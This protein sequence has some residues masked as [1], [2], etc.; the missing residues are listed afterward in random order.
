[1]GHSYRSA[2]EGW[3]KMNMNTMKFFVL[4]GVVSSLPLWAQPTP[5]PTTGDAPC[6]A[7]PSGAAASDTVVSAADDSGFYSMFDGASF[8]GWWQSCQTGHSNG[9]TQ[10]AIFRIDAAQKAIYST[11][12]NG[13]I[14]GILMSAKKYTNYEIVFDLWPDYGN[15]GGLFNRTPPNGNCFQTVLDYIDGAAMGATWGEGGFTARD[16]RPFAFHGAE[17]L[18]TIPGNGAGDPSNWTV[19]TSRLNPT[20]FGCPA[21]GCTQTEWQALWDMDGWNQIRIKFYG[22][23][24]AGTGNIHMKAYFR[25]VGAANWVPLSQDTTLSQIVPPNHI[26][27]QVHGGGRFGGQ[28]GTWYRNIK[29]RTLNDKG[30]PPP[31]TSTFA[32]KKSNSHFDITAS[33]SAL[34]GNLGADHEI[35]VKDMNGRTL[36]T[37]SGHAGKF[38]YSFKSNVHGRLSL[39]VKTAAGVESMSVLRAQ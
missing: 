23:S 25:K 39:Q 17:N 13:N 36:E 26:G 14:G 38:N 10:G 32:A 21:S 8:K 12:R 24:A 33:S 34:I 15:D 29:Y 6:A 18:I 16:Y 19:I 7:E 27:L 31:V 35:I 5:A 1:M 20:S 28:K 22:G 2:M 4:A 30:E 11:Q 3:M 9:S 37:F